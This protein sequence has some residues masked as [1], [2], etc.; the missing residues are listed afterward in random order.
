MSCMSTLDE[1]GH[2]TILPSD[3]SFWPLDDVLCADACDI[4]SDGASGGLHCTGHTAFWT[5][6]VGIERFTIAG[7]P[8]PEICI[9]K[10]SMY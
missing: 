8:E 2:W 5:P 4:P 3:R 9:L 10:I 1:T 7:K 6:S